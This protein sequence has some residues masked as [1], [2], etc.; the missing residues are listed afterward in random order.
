MAEGWTRVSLPTTEGYQQPVFIKFS[1]SASGYEIYLTD[2]GHIWTETLNRREVIKRALTDDTSIDPSEDA[3]QFQLLL[4]KIRDA[5]DGS[6][7]SNVTVTRS[8]RG[9]DLRIATTTKLPAPL[10]PLEWK[11]N[12]SKCAQN[13]F[14]RHIVLP[15]LR[16]ERARENQ[17]RDLMDRLKKKDWVLGKLFNKIEAVGLDLGTV[18]PSAAGVRSAHKGM[19][20]AQAAKSVEG[21]AAFD[22]NTWKAEGGGRDHNKNFDKLSLPGTDLDIGSLE[23]ASDDW[24][25][26]LDTGISTVKQGTS[27][28]STKSRQAQDQETS[29]DSDEDDEFQVGQAADN[30]WFES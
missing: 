1:A 9:N 2:L 30:I 3:E 28:S 4:G 8:S 26:H 22:E 17:L 20:F 6:K 29:G 21:V 12:L 27:F 24:W 13:V 10:Q 16:E 18:F 23:T 14:T 11:F 19:T 15:L 25:D 5:L 7:G